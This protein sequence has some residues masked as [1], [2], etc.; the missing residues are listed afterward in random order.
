MAKSSEDHCH[1]LRCMDAGDLDPLVTEFT[2]HLTVLGHKSLTVS[3]YDAAARHLAQWLTLAKIAVADID[4]GVADR[5]AR[6]RCR[7]HG[8][9]RERSVSAKYVR[10][11][12]RFI[13]FLG[14]RGIVQ[15]KPK[16]ALPTPHR[17]V[18]EFQDWLRQHRGVTELTID[19]HG[20]MV[21]RLLPALGIRPRSWNAQLIR[22]VIIAE[23]KRVSLAY[24][25]TMTMALRG[26]LRFL[27]ARGLCRAGLDQAVPIIP[28][29]RLSSLPRYIRSSDVETLI[30]TCD[31]TT[32]TGVRDR[33][34]LLLLARLGLRAGDILSLRLTDVDWQQ[35]TLSVRGK[36]RRETRLPLPQDAGDA[37]LAYLDQARPHVADV[38]IFFMSNAP[39]RPLTGS[40]A[41]S[42]VVRSAIRKA[43]IPVP[44]NGANLLRHSAATAMLRGG[45]TLDTVG[46]VLRHRSPDMT[47]HYAK[48]DVTMLLQIAQPWP[49]DA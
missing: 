30:A 25:K 8:I 5:F 43:G 41:V 36:G 23:T 24:V 49:G 13:E 14:E 12:R 34:I 29:W 38:R 32:A 39:I 1:G 46:A 4:D 9:R 3:G 10:R 35:A 20:R 2:R 11:V 44:S 26:Y 31:Q 18:V 17:R 47:A 48:V 22:D 6:H 37:L 40:S 19:R 42:D 28:Q 33:A 15:R 21:M 27:S 45:A 7:C 16:P